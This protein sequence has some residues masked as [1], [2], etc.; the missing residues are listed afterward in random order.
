MRY[1]TSLA[2]LLCMVGVAL[3]QGGVSED[4]A[5]LLV[6]F[7]S[8][9]PADCSGQVEVSSGRVTGIRGWRFLAR[10]RVEGNKW[11]AQIRR[12][13]PQG[14]RQ[15][16]AVK[17]GKVLPTTDNGVFIQLADTT[18]DSQVK[19]ST[20]LGE[21]SF[22]LKDIPYGKRLQK[23]RAI[24]IERC[25]PSTCIAKGIE[26]EDYPA[27]A[28]APDGTIW[29][30]YIAFTHGKKFVGLREKMTPD[31]KDF[32]YL[33]EPTGGDRLWLKAFRNGKW[34]E[35]VAVT[36]GGEDLFRPAIA[37]DGSGRVWV[38]FSKNVNPKP[39]L[40]DGNWELMVRSFSNGEFGPAV[41]V[42][43]AAGP[44]LCPV[45][46]TDSEGRVWVA[47]MG[48]RETNFDIFA[49][50]QKDASFGA[51]QRVSVSKANDWTPAIAADKKGNVAVAWDTYDK[52]DYD[53]YLRVFQGGKLGAAM[54][55]GA[56][57]E[58]DSR[59]SLT[60]DK[61]GRLWIAWEQAGPG[62]GKDQG[63]CERNGGGLRLYA[64]RKLILKVW[65]GEK[66]LQPPAKLAA[67]APTR[68]GAKK[69]SKSGKKVRHIDD[70]VRGLNPMFVRLAC[71]S[72]GAIWVAFRGRRGGMRHRVGTVFWSFLTRYDGKGWQSPILLPDS[73]NILDNRP[74]LIPLPDGN[75]L[76]IGSSDE[77]HKFPRGGAPWRVPKW[78]RKR[79]KAKPPK[80]S[81]VDKINNNLYASLVAQ[82]AL[83]AVSDITLEEIPAATVAEPRPDIAIELAAVKRMRDY[84]TNL[85]GETLRLMRGE[86]HRHTEISSDGGGDS[87][88]IDMWRY[89]LDAAYMDWL[90]NGDHDNGGGREYSWWSIQ[91]TTDMLKIGTAFVPMFSYERS[92]SYPE[93]HR[94]VVFAKRGI[95]TLPR[96]PKSDPNDENPPP[97]PDTQ[98]LYRYLR[99]HDGVCAEHT[100]GTNMG[101]D[102]RNNDPVVEPFVEIYQ[103]ARQNYEMPDAPRSNTEENSLG[104]WRPKGFVSL[105]LLRGYRLAFEA[106]SDH[107]STHMS[108][109]NV[110]VTEPTREG[111][112]EGMKKRRVYGSTDD[113]LADVRCVAGGKEHF[114]GEEFE[115]SEPPKFTI[116]LHGTQ[117][118]AKVHVIR[119]NEY[120]YSTEPGKADVDITWADASPVA[121]KTLYYYVRGEQ[122]NGELVWISPMW[123]K[124]SP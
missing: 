68:D 30:A 70:T 109:C 71:D 22:A 52:G 42:S 97:A 29:L 111:I 57:Q 45:A 81:N 107:G 43:N 110:W 116:K 101:T 63:A 103:G 123:I 40:S 56:G 106:S 115:L 93:G 80:D 124:Y 114:M 104:G 31:I 27:A 33:A 61:Q 47:W 95:R 108:Y 5:T 6:T 117:P 12:R 19:I 15:R 73:D 54:P 38:F 48:G 2:L 88:L 34:E 86:F 99:Q 24:T 23:K 112:L 55:V 37:V 9:E 82:S 26:D 121:G 44:D 53:V 35:P 7:R 32:A 67:V 87:A 8:K 1:G 119:Q 66:W 76:V 79:A 51:P 21:M 98:M 96:L 39:D 58:H 18:P 91:K 50:T 90:G 120:V 94:N 122:A 102:W 74:A 17:K 72:Q 20:K 10:D 77:R 36:E 69:P 41:N 89:A 65:D 105:A 11:R 60:Y 59:A 16:Q 113:I 75:L 4:K 13:K 84:R 83:P 85:R 25:A 100:S 118:F 78:R 46:T 64:P 3:G 62:W 28:M 49:A 14:Y 92:V